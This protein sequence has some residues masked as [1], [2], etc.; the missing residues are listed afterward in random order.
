MYD[1]LGFA[2]FQRAPPVKRK[3]GARTFATQ[4][5]LRL[6]SAIDAHLRPLLARMLELHQGRALPS[7]D[8]AMALFDI[9][10]DLALLIEKVV[11]PGQFESQTRKARELLVDG[12]PMPDVMA[13]LDITS[14]PLSYLGSV[15]AEAGAA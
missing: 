12:A 11:K 6:V 4:A 14:E 2:S 9:E 1:Q 15:R 3:R 8:M 7:L 10:R 5:D 13:R